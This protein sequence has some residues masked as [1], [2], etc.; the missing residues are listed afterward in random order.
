MLVGQEAVG[1]GAWTRRGE[2]LIAIRGGWAGTHGGEPARR[3]LHVLND[4]D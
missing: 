1:A 2:E 3:L 4:M